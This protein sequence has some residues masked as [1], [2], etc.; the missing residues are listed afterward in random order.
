MVLIVALLLMIIASIIGITRAG[1]VEKSYQAVGCSAAITFDDIAN[2]NIS[3]TGKFFIGLNPLM[4]G[5]NDLKTNKNTVKT[6]M[7]KLSYSTGGS[8]L[9][10]AYTAGTAVLT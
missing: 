6:E 2:G 1:D 4:K 7:D 10:N 9:N 5:L 8:H 3:S